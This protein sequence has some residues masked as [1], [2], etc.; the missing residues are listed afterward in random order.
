MPAARAPSRAYRRSGGG[1]LTCSRR[2]PLISLGFL[3]EGRLQVYAAC[4]PVTV[5]AKSTELQAARQ[6]TREMS[7]FSVN[8]DQAPSADALAAVDELVADARVALKACPRS[9]GH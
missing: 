3:R 5:A 9:D 7:V 2:W 4:D 6:E 1:R 8:L